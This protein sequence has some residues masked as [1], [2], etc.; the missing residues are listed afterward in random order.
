L[1]FLAD[2]LFQPG[3]NLTSGFVRK[4]DGKNTRGLFAAGDEMRNSLREDPCLT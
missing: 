3:F 1:G 2:G 4:S